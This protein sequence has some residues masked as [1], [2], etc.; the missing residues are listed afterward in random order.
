MATDFRKPF[1]PDA[2]SFDLA[3]IGLIVGQEFQ[4]RLS[5][6]LASAQPIAAIVAEIEHFF[7]HGFQPLVELEIFQAILRG[8][9]GGASDV[10]K[11][12]QAATLPRSIL[13]PI[14][15]PDILGLLFPGGD[16][17]EPRVRLPAIENAALDLFTRRVFDA[18]EYYRLG[19][20][21][22]REAFTISA[23]LTTDQLEEVRDVLADTI[24]DGASLSEFSNRLAG[25]FE[26]GLPIS[27]AHL[28]NVFRSNTMQAYSQGH[29][30]ILGHELVK[31]AFPFR[32]YTALHDART[33]KNHRALETMGLDGT[34]VYWA[35]DPVWQRFRPPWDFQCRCGWIALSIEG[36]A[37]QGVKAAI[38]WMRTGIEPAREFV[39]MPDFAPSAS[40]DSHALAV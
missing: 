38:E 33:R 31:D 1:T 27:P 28:E 20:N 36:A 24:S 15:P 35:D 12:P 18:G 2:S 11:Y 17:S 32:L 37:E 29:D 39:P 3:G 26:G 21:A 34:A 9:I 13:P 8:W 6:I 25:R 40:W 19:A 10:F 7:L 14:D 23:D 4:R 5:A 16:G 30:H 22:R